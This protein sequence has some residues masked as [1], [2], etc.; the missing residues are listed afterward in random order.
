MLLLAMVTEP[1]RRSFESRRRRDGAPGNPIESAE[2]YGGRAVTER[3]D[4][5]RHGC[6]TPDH[7][8]RG[9]E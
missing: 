6:R 7:D 1:K 9:K 8:D 4:C 2:Q 3:M 5:E